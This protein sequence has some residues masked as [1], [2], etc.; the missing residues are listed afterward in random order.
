[1]MWLVYGMADSNFY[2]AHATL[3]LLLHW[4]CCLVRQPS[5]FLRLLP[6]ALVQ[7]LPRSLL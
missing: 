2:S 1:M 6:S 3:Y 4:S 7:Q 5:S